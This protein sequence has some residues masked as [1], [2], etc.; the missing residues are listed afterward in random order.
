MGNSCPATG[1]RVSV[2]RILWSRLIWRHWKAEVR[3]TLVLVG[4][5]SLGVAVFLSVRL[6]NK[7]AVSGFGMFTESIAGESDFILRTRA[8]DI[9]ES[10]LTD[11]R[12]A[13]GTIAVGAFPVLE[14]SAADGREGE[15]GL[16]RLV[17]VDLVALQNARE[18]AGET[19]DARPAEAGGESAA[20]E[21]SLGKRDEAFGGTEFARR[22]GMKEGDSLPLIVSDQLARVQL[23]GILPEDPN[24]A[25]IPD[26][27]LVMDLPGL[28]DLAGR[29]GALS[30]IE[31]RVP[32]G[33]LRDREKE[34]AR[35]AL[36]DFVAEHALILETPEDRKESVTTMSAAFRLNLTILSGLALLV[37]MYLIMQ[38]MEAAVVKRRAEIAIL[39]S[40]GVTPGQVRSAWL[41]EGLVLGTVGAL[42]GIVLGRLLAEGLVGAIARTVNTLYYETT[43]TA[44]TL[45]WGEVAFCLGFGV[46]ASLLATWI[47]A[48]E[49]SET[50]PA[51]TMRQGTQGGGLAL[52]RMPRWGLAF[53]ALGIGCCFLP[54]FTWK[55][56]TVVPLGGYLA[57]VFLVIAA[58]VLV[59]N[60]FRPVAALLK[61]RSGHPVRQYAASQLRRPAGR[62]RLTAAG[63]AVAIGMSAAMGI[64]VSSFENTLTSWIQQLLRADI[65]LSAAGPN[66]VTNENIISERSWREVEMVPGVAGMD[67]IRRYTVSGDGGDFFL[68]GSEYNND[69]ERYL[70]L[71]WLKPPDRTGPRSL[72]TR[73]GDAVPGWASEALARKWSLDIGDRFTFPTPSGEETAEI[74]GVYADYGNETGTLIVGRCFTSEWF[75]DSDVSNIALY[76]SE[77]A[78]AETVLAEIEERFPTL[79]ART[80]ARLRTESIRIF[81]QTF[82][83]TY[84]L[85]AIAVLIAVTGLGLALTGLLLERKAELSTLRAV[86]ASRAEIGRA[87]MWEGIGLS[88]VGLVGGLLL[89]FLLGWVLIHVINPQSFGWTLTYRV[90]W[91]GF[92]LLA[93]VSI[94]TAALVSRWIGSRSALLQ[95]DQEE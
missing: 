10:I 18:L 70:Q 42:L 37:G 30:R 28:Q 86:G 32:P 1:R 55:G 78:D 29:D 63:L 65:Y 24:R 52:L 54:P 56:A 40:L 17:G 68:G 9:D 14:I 6:A 5:L 16:V 39:R 38:A 4:I 66:T 31:L 46:L 11:L 84:A 13:L 62:H 15:E 79:V 25:A 93:V 95:S 21:F 57:A 85:E 47:P 36:S 90:P 94:A 87:A 61:G 23:A 92:L 88:V 67:R 43:T 81:H 72:E 74:A 83:V 80:N 20:R 75:D 59:G 73:I 60:L 50:P 76:V 8:G 27:L 45:E 64:L 34:R 53:L 3:L 12:A 51:Q 48:R 49:A 2:A 35:G 89:S 41:I 58:S 7:A 91:L 44:I 82:A 33:P 69:S 26:H 77:D 19:S 22:F 71:I